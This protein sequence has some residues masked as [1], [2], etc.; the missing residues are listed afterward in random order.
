MTLPDLKGLFVVRIG[1]DLRSYA[2]VS[3]IPE[4][5]DNLIRFKPDFPEG[6]H[7]EEQHA[8]IAGFGEVLRMLMQR[9]TK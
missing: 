1:S 9:E 6:P 7:T 3:E 8:E 4:Q 2:R 5:F